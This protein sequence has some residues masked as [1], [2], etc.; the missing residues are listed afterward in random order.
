MVGAMR[1]SSNKLDRY[2]NKI[3]DFHY[4]ASIIERAFKTKKRI[5]FVNVAKME[6]PTQAHQNNKNKSKSDRRFLFFNMMKFSSK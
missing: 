1:S 6:I 5:F 2:V 4:G 3:M